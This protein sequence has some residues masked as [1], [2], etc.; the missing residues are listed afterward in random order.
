[1]TGCTPNQ[2]QEA[3]KKGDNEILNKANETELKRKK[4]NLSKQVFQIRNLV[5]LYQPSDKT[6]QIWSNTI[7]TVE[8]VFK[9]Q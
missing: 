7:Y 8:K 1:M 4:G 9:P 5:R 6:R 3:F 2:I